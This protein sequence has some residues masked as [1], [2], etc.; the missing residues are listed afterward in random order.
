MNKWYTRE[1]STT[2]YICSHVAKSKGLISILNGPRGELVVLFCFIGG[3]MSLCQKKKKQTTTT[4]YNPR[5]LAWVIAHLSVCLSNLYFTEDLR[6]YA[7]E[8]RREDARE[9]SSYLLGPA[10]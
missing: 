2:Y 10:I 9:F 5:V 8:D 4:L 6:T 7:G 1:Y 3:F